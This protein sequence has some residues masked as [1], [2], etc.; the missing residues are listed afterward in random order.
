MLIVGFGLL[1]G[2]VG[3]NKGGNGAAPA[4]SSAAAS[5][6]QKASLTQAQLEEAY[7][8][9]DADNYDKSVA[10][11]TGKLGAPQKTEPDTTIWYGVSADGSS[12]YQLKLTKTKGNETGTVDKA[13][14]GI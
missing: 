11:V 8:L 12:C 14:C 13:N 5:S 1:I 7:K 4:G 6:A 2:L 3:C 10:A 9:T